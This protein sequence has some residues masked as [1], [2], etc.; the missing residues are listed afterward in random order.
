[1]KFVFVRCV[2][3]CFRPL[4]VLFFLCKFSL[5]NVQTTQF[6][7]YSMW[8]V[9]AMRIF[10]ATAL[11]KW[12]K[13][14]KLL[15]FHIKPAATWEKHEIRFRPLRKHVLIFCCKFSLRN[16]QT[17]QFNLYRMWDVPAMRIFYATA[18]RKWCKIDKLLIFHIKPAATWE[19]HE[20][21]FSSVA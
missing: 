4:R 3:I 8:D 1:M 14:D 17:T 19:K 6:N 18:L 20:H 5:R 21:S 11:R 12:C 13:I 15:I 10:Y 2:S 7:L 16:V 9:P